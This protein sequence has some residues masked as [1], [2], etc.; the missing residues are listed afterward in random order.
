MIKS[1]IYQPKVNYSSC[2]NKTYLPIP[3]HLDNYN[4]NSNKHP[5]SSHKHAMSSI[6]PSQCNCHVQQHCN[7]Q[8]WKN[9]WLQECVQQHCLVQNNQ[10]Q[11]CVQLIGCHGKYGECQ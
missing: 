3:G 8:G 6:E 1:K 7:V 5:H 4:V 2:F 10:S 11:H 9:N